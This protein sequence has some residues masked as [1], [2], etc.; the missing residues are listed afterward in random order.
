MEENLILDNTNQIK[1]ISNPI[2]YQMFNML[3]KKS[4]TGSQIAR[5]LNI[6]RQR[7]HYHLKILQDVGIIHLEEEKL[8]KGMLEKYYLSVA[9]NITMSSRFG[10]DLYN[11]DKPEDQEIQ[12]KPFKDIKTIILKQAEADLNQPDILKKISNLRSSRQ[13]LVYLSPEQEREASQQLNTV[14]EYFHNLSNKNLETQKEQDLLPIRYTLLITPPY[15]PENISE[16]EEPE[17]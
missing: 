17:S 10:D 16:T 5:A 9:K 4:M 7:A 6:P 3:T 12:N 1:A 8:K 15:L 11:V 14:L 13:Y 2:R